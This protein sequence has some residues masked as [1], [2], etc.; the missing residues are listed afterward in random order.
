MVNAHDASD[1]IGVGRRRAW[2]AGGLVLLALGIGSLAVPLAGLV[3]TGG[4][5]GGL[6]FLL[7]AVPPI[8]AGYG[9]LRQIP[10]ARVLGFTVALA[11]AVVVAYTATTP[12]R[13]LAPAQGQSSPPLDPGTVLVAVAFLISAVLIAVGRPDNQAGGR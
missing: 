3:A 8:A 5:L 7:L 10:W 6:A 12:W 9:A 13:G 11:Y 2:V 4:R 1:V